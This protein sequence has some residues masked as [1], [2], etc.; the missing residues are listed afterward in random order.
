MNDDLS[1]WTI[2][3]I[4]AK[5]EQLAYEAYM[6]NEKH[7]AKMGKIDSEIAKLMREKIRRGKQ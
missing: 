7:R 4:T 5:I 6:E 3:Q 1:K 2:T